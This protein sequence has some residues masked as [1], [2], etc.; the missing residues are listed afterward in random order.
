MLIALLALCLLFSILTLK[1]QPGSGPSA[2][3]EMVGI[4]LNRISGSELTVI[5][6]ASNTDS[7]ILARNVYQQVIASGRDT[8]RLIV[9]T[10]R[11]LRLALDE[12]AANRQPL[13]GIVTS[14]DAIK[15]RVIEQIPINFPQFFNY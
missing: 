2:E 10:P 1:R 5:V 11:D 9:G 7:E 14:G 6:G 12:M 3:A 4:V 8:A 15:W 13:G